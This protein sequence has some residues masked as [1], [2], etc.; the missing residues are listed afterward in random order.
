MLSKNELSQAVLDLI[1]RNDLQEPVQLSAPV[2]QAENL[3]PLCRHLFSDRARLALE[4]PTSHLIYQY[5]RPTEPKATLLE[6]MF[7]LFPA[8][9]E[10]LEKACQDISVGYL[11]DLDVVEFVGST[12]EL[13]DIHKAVEKVVATVNHFADKGF[14]KVSLLP[15]SMIR[16]AAMPGVIP[17]IAV[18]SYISLTR[19]GSEYAKTY[20]PNM[21]F[22]EGECPK[23]VTDQ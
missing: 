23:E 14:M 13:K 18:V 1:N 17:K 4:T 15:L 19:E 5:N 6:L 3:Y 12:C 10:I 16:F 11:R 2:P 9:R 20:K 7:K 22:S 21:M 8:Q